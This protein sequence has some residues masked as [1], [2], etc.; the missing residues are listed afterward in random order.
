MFLR[1][2]ATV[3]YEIV[4]VWVT[5]RLSPLSDRVAVVPSTVWYGITH[6]VPVRQFMVPIAAIVTGS[7]S[8]PLAVN[9]G[10]NVAV[11]VDVVCAYGQILR[12]KPP[13]AVVIS[14]ARVVSVAMNAVFVAVSPMNH[15]GEPPGRIPYGAVDIGV[16]AAAPPG[17]AG[18]DQRSTVNTVFVPDV[19][20]TTTP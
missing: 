11:F 17:V 12:I 14:E 8:E 4:K 13:E 6:V 7:E 15:A 2:G 5:V 19:F 10:V 1:T 9:T 18:T 3:S 16:V 20:D